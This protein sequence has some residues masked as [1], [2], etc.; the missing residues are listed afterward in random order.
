MA[1]GNTLYFGDNL[2]VLKEYVKDETVDLVYLDPP[3]NSKAS[4]NILFK[5]PVGEKSDAQLHAFQDTW[6]WE[7][8]AE[9]AM[10]EV[11]KT[12]VAILN[13]LTSLKSFLGESDLMA[14]LAMMAPRL[15]ELRRVL[16]RNGSIYLHCDPTASHYLKL[17]L[18]GVFGPDHFQNEIIW[19]RHSAHSSAKRYGPVHDVLL[20]FSKGDHFTWT[21]P[22]T[23]YAEEYLD[24]YYKYDDGD[25][26]LYWRNSL[27]AAGTRNGSSG[28]EWRGHNPTEQGSHWKFTIENLDALDKAGKIYWPPGGGWPQIKRYRDELKGLAIG[29]IWDDIDK[30]NPAGNERLRYPT[31]KPVALLNRIITA[32]SKEGDVILDP[33]CGCGTAIHAAEDLKRQWIGIDITYLAIQVIEDRLKTW[34]PAAKYQLT[35]IPNDELAARKLAKL[36]PYT[37]QLWAVGKVGGQPRGKGADKGIDGEI[38]FLRG[39]RDYGRGIISVKAGQHVNPDMVRAL[40]GTVDRER[41]DVGIFICLDEPTR[42][43]KTEAHTGGRIDLPGGNR[44]RIQIVTVPELISGPNLGII[45]TLN[46]IQAAEAVRAASRVRKKR[47]KKPTAA[48]LRR[49]PQIPLPIKG[50]RAK[51]QQQP[52]PLN[53][54]LLVPTPKT[55]RRNRRTS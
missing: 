24:R 5:S 39:V 8:G 28:E 34:L 14:Y 47:K 32:S 41:A 26:R 36:D 3:F 16:K 30:I 10:A 35:G 48:E 2:H 38:A 40:K 13:L 55:P 23:G 25:G 17:L 27:T 20:F 18:D 44:P 6:R 21:N 42:D 4:Y 12:N 33:F 1:I 51:E 43:M 19:K 9:Q 52:L 31:Q 37:F 29:D 11:A 49:Q 54:P 7:D 22:R 53:D 45:T 15:L 46:T 50:G